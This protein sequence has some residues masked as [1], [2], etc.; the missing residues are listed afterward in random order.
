MYYSDTIDMFW[1]LVDTLN[2]HLEND[3]GIEDIKITTNIRADE[4]GRFVAYIGLDTYVGCFNLQFS[5]IKGMQE[6]NPGCKLVSFR[7]EKS[8]Q[9]NDIMV[10]YHFIID[11]FKD[12][13]SYLYDEE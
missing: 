5:W 10:F 9:S 8:V 7:D 12:L 3:L 1:A 2:K 4:P 6:L 13:Y 11:G